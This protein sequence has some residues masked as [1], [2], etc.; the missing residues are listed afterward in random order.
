MVRTGAQV[1]GILLNLWLINW[2]LTKIAVLFVKYLPCYSQKC[3]RRPN[4]FSQIS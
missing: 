1:G 2:T 3:F 4:T